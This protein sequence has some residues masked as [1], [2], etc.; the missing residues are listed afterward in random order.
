M[1][2]CFLSPMKIECLSNK[3]H[4]SKCRTVAVLI[5]ALL[6]FLF[7]HSFLYPIHPLA[8][9]RLPSVPSH[10]THTHVTYSQFL[11]QP[12]CIYTCHLAIVFCQILSHA[13]A[14]FSIPNSFLLPAKL[15][16]NLYFAF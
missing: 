12:C 16:V 15:P 4:L 2:A 11:N 14:V 10:L 9:Q 6:L 5:F 3:A 8:L 13:H 7:F 1:N